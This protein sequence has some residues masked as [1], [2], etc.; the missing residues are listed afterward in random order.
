RVHILNI[1]DTNTSTD[2]GVLVNQGTGGEFDVT[3][4]Y[5]SVKSIEIYRGSITNTSTFYDGGT[6]NPSFD[7][8]GQIQ[9]IGIT[10]DIA[11]VTNEGVVAFR[12]RPYFEDYSILDLDA[13]RW[14]SSANAGTSAQDHY[15]FIIGGTGPFNS[16]LDIESGATY[17]GQLYCGWGADS[18]QAYN[19]GTINRVDLDG[20][21]TTR[22]LSVYMNNSSVFD[23]Y[24]IVDFRGNMIA[25][26]SIF[27]NESTGT[28]SADTFG[29]LY[30]NN[31]GTFNNNADAIT[32]VNQIII[33]NA[34]SYYYQDERS[35]SSATKT[36][37]TTGLIDIESGGAFQNEDL[38]QAVG[39]SVNGNGSYFYQKAGVTASNSVT[40]LTAASTIDASSGTATVDIDA[41]T[42]ITTNNAFSVDTGGDVDNSGILT[43]TGTGTN[44]LQVDGGNY[45][46]GTS[47]TLNLAG[48][49]GMQMSLN[50]STAEIAGTTPGSPSF[51]N[52]GGELCLGQWNVGVGGP[53]SNCIDSTNTIT[54]GGL[55]VDTLNN[56]TSD[57]TDVYIGSNLT[58]QGDIDVDSLDDAAV[59]VDITQNSSSYLQIT[60]NGDLSINEGSTGQGITFTSG[61]HMDIQGS[62][63]GNH[64]HIRA[65]GDA[66]V[67]LNHITDDYDIGSLW[68][69]ASNSEAASVTLASGATLNLND[70][71]TSNLG[72]AVITLNDNNGDGSAT[73]TTN[74]TTNLNS[75]STQNLILGYTTSTDG[76]GELEVGS[77]GY[78]EHDEIGGSSGNVDINATGRLEVIAD[79][80]AD[81]DAD[82][83]GTLT[84]GGDYNDG[85]GNRGAYI[86]GQLENE[87]TLTIESAGFMDVGANGDVTV[88]GSTTSVSGNMELDGTLNS[89]DLTVTSTGVISSGDGNPTVSGSGC[90]VGGNFGC[91][92]SSNFYIN[93]G[94][95]I[96]NS[97]GA[98]SSDAVSTVVSSDTGGGSHG[99]EG[100]G[101]TGTGKTYGKVK[102]DETGTPT[103]G[104][105]TNAPSYGQAGY[106]GAAADGKGGGGVRIYSNGDFTNNGTI[107][108]NGAAGT[109]YSGAGGTVIIVHQPTLSGA[110]FIGDGP[111]T[112]NGGS[113]TNAGGG[114]RVIIKSPLLD[115]PDFSSYD[116][117]E[118][119]GSVSAAPGAG[120][121]AAGTVVYLGDG[122]NDGTGST[123]YGTLIVDQAGEASTVQTEIPTGAGAGD[124][125]FARVDARDGADVT[126]AADP[127]TDPTVCFDNDNG[128]TV[129]FSAGSCNAYPDK[130]DSLHI[131]TSWVGTTPATATEEP[132]YISPTRGVDPT[133]YSI[134][135]IKPVFAMYFKNP[136]DT[137]TEHQYVE[138]QVDDTSAAFGSII[139]DATSTGTGAIDLGATAALQVKDGEWTRDIEYNEDGNA[140]SGLTAGT[141]YFVRA[142]FRNAGD[143]ASGLWTH[144]DYNSHY[145]FTPSSYG[146]IWVTNCNDGG[147]ASTNMVITQDGTD[148]GDD[149]IPTSTNRYGYGTCDVHVSTSETKWEVYSS[150]D[151]GEAAFLHTNAS[152]TIAPINN[153]TDCLIND[154][155][156]DGTEEYGFNIQTYTNTTDN[157]TINANVKADT[158]CGAIQCAGLGKYNES[159]DGDYNNNCY[160]DFETLANKDTILD[161]DVST[162][163]TLNDGMYTMIMHSNINWSTVAGDYSVDG[164]VSITTFP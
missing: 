102:L 28:V 84:V 141:P 80:N 133:V 101:I 77:G 121:G 116:V 81:K 51:Q 38:V 60:Q 59:S 139:W 111:I 151:T 76:T 160:F 69:L 87:T 108:A 146:E 95:V 66:T 157:T 53:A 34:G 118:D 115:D 163:A 8:G 2:G 140:L 107:S 86:G 63:L 97:G 126:Y 75:G 27:N 22:Y 128:S 48:T 67:S 43:L 143:T 106:T 125:E 62:G 85:T 164:I 124:I 153:P 112:A 122:H 41:G 89:G 104:D 58:V 14:V 71:H 142:R 73:F 32:T 99:G 119:G 4:Y 65:E 57:D 55:T 138:I 159:Q 74:G 50:T 21:S 24:G 16:V 64:G 117:G 70:T 114:G 29:S 110:Y 3:Y 39:L 79:A 98:I 45:E 44:N 10:G 42:T 11:T 1:G 155:G 94:D 56:T 150:M 123:V 152:D 135:D 15:T 37:T 154:L 61:G 68:L 54:L 156:T 100:E 91:G 72:A 93:A 130:P 120:G 96:I 148:I 35:A 9:A 49:P 5:T 134:G 109:T 40:T 162:E 127:T 147:G 78:I 145:K 36:T 144:A 20:V 26:N 7:I 149:M 33:Q 18:C 25:N 137:A 103:Y 12:E 17:S 105:S 90:G 129:T 88:D 158:E 30:A 82:F 83:Y 6:D 161:T 46:S 23:N 13:G 113:G 131:Q 31:G 47:S 52:K 92:S 19:D 132:G 136:E